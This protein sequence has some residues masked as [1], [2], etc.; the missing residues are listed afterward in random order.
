MRVGVEGG[1]GVGKEG[2]E[3]GKGVGKEGEGDEWEYGREINSRAPENLSSAA[4]PPNVI[5]KRRT[6]QRAVRSTVHVFSQLP[7][8]PSYK[9]SAAISRAAISRAAISPH[10]PGPT[11]DA[12]IP[13]PI[14]HR[15]QNPNRNRPNIFFIRAN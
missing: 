10:P 14:P 11:T 7:H 8:P 12:P 15:P 6:Q 3:G 2:V 9:E 13:I 1:K 5:S 4:M